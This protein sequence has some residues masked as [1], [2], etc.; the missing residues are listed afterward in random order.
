MSKVLKEFDTIMRGDYGNLILYSGVVGLAL[1]NKF[2][3]PNAVIGK[4]TLNKIKR[5]YDTGDISFFEFKERSEKTLNLYKNVWW[6]GVLAA[7]FF[8]KGDVYQKAKIGGILLASGV[9]ASFLIPAP[10]FSS[11]ALLDSAEDN[12]INFEGEQKM[13]VAKIIKFS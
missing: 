6:G 7:M 8:T 1:S 4:F 12:N 9:I 2:P 5:S 10:D 11:N 13:K 3:T